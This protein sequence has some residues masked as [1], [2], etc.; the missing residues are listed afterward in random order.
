MPTD[1]VDKWLQE[2]NQEALDKVNEKYPP[3][4]VEEILKEIKEEAD[5]A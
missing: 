1:P 5:D 2:Q 4:R 3:E